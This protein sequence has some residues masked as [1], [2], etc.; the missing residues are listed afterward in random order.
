MPG[1]RIQSVP[2][3]LWRDLRY[4]ARTLRVQPGFTAAALLMLALGVGATAAIFSVV[5]A[6]LIK[7]LPFPDSDAL[8]N[9]VHSVNGADLAYFSDRVYLTY[10]ENNQTFQEFGVWSAGT[11]SITGGGAPEQVRT[12]VVTR[13][14]LPALGMQ[15]QIGRGFREKTV[16]RPRTRPCCSP[17]PSGSG[18]SE[19]TEALWSEG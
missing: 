5:N 2:G 3:D 11:A 12:L 7:P 18:G 10:A 15:P 17:T 19:A 14:V 6:V 1:A 13:E 9:V 16:A 8:V 4:A